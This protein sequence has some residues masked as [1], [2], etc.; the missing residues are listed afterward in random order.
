MELFAEE[1]DV[2]EVELEVLLDSLNVVANVSSGKTFY[3]A[4]PVYYTTT[5]GVEAI[6]IGKKLTV[7]DI[8]RL[9]G[10]K[11]RGNFR[12]DGKKWNAPLEVISIS[13]EK[14]DTFER[15]KMDVEVNKRISRSVQ[16]E[17]RG[18]LLSLGSLDRRMRTLFQ[19]FNLL[20]TK[21]AREFG[22]N[23]KRLSEILKEYNGKIKEYL[24]V[25][26]DD[27]LVLAYAEHNPQE[28][29]HAL[30]V[31]NVS[32]AIYLMG[33][34]NLETS[35]DEI[36]KEVRYLSTAAI[37]HDCAD[38]FLKK[39][40]LKREQFKKV[41]GVRDFIIPGR[42]F[43][44]G[45]EESEERVCIDGMTFDSLETIQHHHTRRDGRL[46]IFPAVN[47]GDEK[48]VAYV[49]RD[50]LR[51][52]ASRGRDAEVQSILLAKATTYQQ[53]LVR[54]VV[55]EISEIKRDLFQ[56]LYLAER[57]VSSK[58]RLEASVTA[59]KLMKGRG[60]VAKGEYVDALLEIIDKNYE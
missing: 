56:P 16:K 2:S 40:G 5:S 57:W 10:E 17:R 4:E 14:R 7:D 25:L 38:S 6:N 18:A 48:N 24:D 26:K 30:D 42:M 58:T 19:S 21:V 54:G 43:T 12:R 51:I 15:F 33:S 46:V 11:T 41:F 50:A 8:E 49:S 31:L 23:Q 59:N 52:S 34:R 44:S 60:L 9:T 20:E 45:D 37:V 22:E 39:S 1:L 35:Q 27:P 32:T 36:D 29:P 47:G 53:E 28:L 13:P 55:D 3:S